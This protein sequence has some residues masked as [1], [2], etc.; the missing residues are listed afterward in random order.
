MAVGKESIAFRNGL[1]GKTCSL[2][3]LP[4]ME[5][6]IHLSLAAGPENENSTGL[7]GSARRL[8]PNTSNE[9]IGHDVYQPLKQVTRSE[10]P[11]H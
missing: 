6:S 7:R 3:A 10:N 1:P 4:S 11:I 8:L 9:S 5:G 2:A